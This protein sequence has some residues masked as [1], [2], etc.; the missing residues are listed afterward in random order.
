MNMDGTSP[1]LIKQSAT[2]QNATIKLDM[3]LGL[4]VDRN[5]KRLFFGN[6]AKNIIDSINYSGTEKLTIAK[7]KN[8]KTVSIT[9]D[10][11][12]LYWAESFGDL[13]EIFSM[14]SLSIPTPLG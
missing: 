3:K 7:L 12:R 14:V 5:K 10:E 6:R 13:R 1:V 9:T 8:I 11:K 4:A 2:D